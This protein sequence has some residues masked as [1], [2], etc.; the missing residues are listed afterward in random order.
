MVSSMIFFGCD[1]PKQA[2]AP[3]PEVAAVTIQPEHIVLTTEL[4]GRTS[5]YRIAE[6][7]P[8]VNGIVLKRLFR[9]G[10]DVL[11][12]QELYLI[13]PAPF[14]AAVDSAK[15]ALAKSEANLPAIRSR[16]ERY[17]GLLAEKAVSQQDYDDREAALKQ[18]EADIEYW[19][20]AL[21]TARINLKYTR[22]TAPISG[23]IGKSNITD[24]A[25]VTAY[26]QLPLSTIQQIDPIYVDLPQ[27]T[28]ELLRLKSHL[29][30]GRLN[31]NG[32]S[33]RKVLLFL[34][35]GAEYPMTGTLQFRDVTVD[36]S[37][38]SVILRIVF[39]NPE[40]LLLPGMFV[41]A[42][43]QEGISEQ[44][45]LVPQQ[46]VSRDPKGNPSV[47]TVD[48]EGRAQQRMLK[49]DR[50]IGDRWLVA[51]GLSGGDRVIVEGLQRIRPG[52]AVR[53]VSVESK[54]K[55]QDQAGEPVKQSPGKRDGGA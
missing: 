37:T 55:A 45:I 51:S 14:Q 2:A 13:D 43:V 42:R 4:P 50:A 18:A 32:K 15:A 52:S 47:F 19:K 28:T 11:E 3:L 48:S 26:Q 21:E 49:L 30:E 41:R 44:A 7:R 27:S 22:V 46:A 34:K 36:P 54:G 24:G 5:A 25:L 12:G 33:Q 20:A 35:D 39:P 8:Q 1:K 23:R 17:R 53:V 31:V 40:G 16:A 9:E 29:E 10:T 6:I 38:A